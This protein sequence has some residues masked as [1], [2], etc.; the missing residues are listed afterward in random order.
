VLESLRRWHDA[1]AD[2]P[3]PGEDRLRRMLPQRVS[4]EVLSALVLDLL[5]EGKVAREGSGISL[6]GHRPALLAADAALWDRVSALLDVDD[7][8]PPRVREIAEELDVDLRTLEQLFARVTRMHMVHRVADNRYY[9]TETLRQLGH[10][11]ESIAGKSPDGMFDARAF[12]DAS[13]IGRNVA[14]QV[15]EFFDG[16]GLT[17]REGDARRIHRPAAEVFE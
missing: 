14:I 10:V 5:R 6:A 16:L 4:P 7:M 12:R 17:R 15:L 13:G 2:Q 3:G 9:L 11:A 8:R 1:H